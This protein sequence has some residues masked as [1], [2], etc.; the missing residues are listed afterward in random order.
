MRS[1]PLFA[2][3]LL[4]FWGWQL[5]TLW[6]AAGLACILESARFVKLRFDFKPSD[7]NTVVD[8]S[9]M[10]MAGTIVI[11]LTNDA[12]KALLTLLKWLPVLLFPIM[13]AQTYSSAGK[14]DIHSFFLVTRK[15][16]KQHFYE[17][18]KIDITYVY[19]LI[20]ILSAGSAARSQT[21]LFFPGVCLFT[22]WGLG[23]NRSRRYPFIPWLLCL[24]IIPVTGYALYQGIRFTRSKLSHLAMSYYSRFY[25][26]HPMKSFTAMGDIGR[27]KLSDNIILRVSFNGTVPGTP[28][29]LHTATYNKFAASNWFAKSKFITINHSADQTFWPVNNDPA[30]QKTRQVTVYAR[31]WKR[32][33]V[34]SLPPGVI[35][36]AQME[37]KS[38]EQNQLQTIRAEGVGGFYKTLATCT[39]HPSFDANPDALDLFIPEKELPGI[40]RFTENLP[41]KDK[42]DRQKLKLVEQHFLKNFT[43]S[44]ELKG[45]GQYGTPVQNFLFHTKSGHCEFFATATALILRQAGIPTRY[46]TGFIAHERS[47]LGNHLIVRQRD[48]HAWTKVFINGHWENFDTTPPSMFDIDSQKVRPSWIK[49]AISFLVFNVSRFSHDTGKD[50]MNR[51]GLWLI[52]PLAVILFIRLKRAGRIKREKSRPKISDDKILSRVDPAFSTLE[53]A[54]SDAGLA[55][56]PSETG[57]TWGKRIERHLEP[58]DVKKTFFTILRHHEHHRFSKAG[59]AMAQKAELDKQIKWFLKTWE[60]RPY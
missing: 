31:S 46:S 22:L 13:A 36:I 17:P 55:R 9:T 32:K 16:I 51:Y 37:A 24:C 6:I 19:A 52:L 59:L 34:L 47:L 25:S 38:L 21:A 20:C 50:L 30:N 41:F 45:K 33:T 44:L 60:K 3:T 39:D 12:E 58:A 7:F 11:A 26:A 54:L 56:H 1:P 42:S 14:I 10:L 4:L 18:K 57:L 28:L 27:L 48:A 53:S 40:T 8:I 23:Q 35:S 29:L 15:K 43:Y 49:D 5:D 2:G